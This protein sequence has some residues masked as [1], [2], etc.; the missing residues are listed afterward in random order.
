MSSNEVT[1][2][3][4]ENASAMDQSALAEAMVALLKDHSGLKIRL[5]QVPFDWSSGMHRLTS[6]FH[7]LTFADGVPTI[8]EFVEYLYDCLIP[9]CLP[10]KK[11]R[12]AL[13]GINPAVDYAR[14]VRLHDD[15]KSLFIKAKNQLESGGE[16]GELILYVLLGRELIIP[17]P[18]RPCP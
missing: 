11:V 14:I 3:E 4:G 18:P 2:A 12:D 1:E 17:L 15:A 6:S 8:Q 10:K 9:Y 7:Y 16:P 13:Q 5:K